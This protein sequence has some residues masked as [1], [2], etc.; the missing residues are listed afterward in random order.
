[1][2]EFV[3]VESLVLS[4]LWFAPREVISTFLV[5]GPPQPITATPGYT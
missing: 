1:M 2:E 4:C 3:T 5:I